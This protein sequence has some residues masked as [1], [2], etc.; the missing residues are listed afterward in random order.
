MSRWPRTGLAGP[1]CRIKG[2]RA[3]HDARMS[4]S[5]LFRLAAAAWFLT[6]AARA[7][8]VILGVGP[9]GGTLGGSIGTYGLGAVVGLVVGWLHWVRP[10]LQTALIG[11]AF[12]L[13]SVA[14][15]AYLPFIGP[16]P[17][18][19]L[20]SATGLLAFGLSVA[21]LVAARRGRSAA[22]PQ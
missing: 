4:E 16:E 15:L 20:L 21:C 9:T 17:W 6:V 19:L 11:T 18:F 2:A 7:V 3:G 8:L 10:G 12:G 22:P 13:L 14:G 5:R 1:V